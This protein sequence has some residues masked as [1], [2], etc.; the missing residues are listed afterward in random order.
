MERL[1]APCPVWQVNKDTKATAQTLY[2][3]ISI[4]VGR[5]RCPYR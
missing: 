2:I 5:Y 4:R 3:P 1:I